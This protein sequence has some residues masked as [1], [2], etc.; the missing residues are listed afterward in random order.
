MA[1]IKAYISGPIS[2]NPNYEEEF[3]AAAEVL[4]ALSYQPINPV[5]LVKDML[6]E[7]LSAA[8]LWK[9]AMEIDLA[10]LKDADIVVL[11]D[12]KELPS[13]GMDIE[14]DTAR[15]LDIPVIP[16]DHLRR[17]LERRKL[18]EQGSSPQKRRMP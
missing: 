7:G 15:K 6:P 18:Y 5:E 13:T 12:R 4:K 16:I 1:V 10:A 3:A 14:I 8:E 2:A 17:I 11:I 9:K